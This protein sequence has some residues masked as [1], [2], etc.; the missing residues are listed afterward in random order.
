MRCVNMKWIRQVLWKIQSGHVCPTRW[1]PVYPL[2]T[3]LSEGYNIKAQMDITSHPIDEVVMT[4]PCL[5]SMLVSVFSV[6]KRRP[7]GTAN[8]HH[9]H[10][11]QSRLCLREYL[12]RSCHFWCVP[13]WTSSPQT[14]VQYVPWNMAH[15][16]FLYFGTGQFD[17]HPSGLLHWHCGNHMVAP[18]PVK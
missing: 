8:P 1:N 7:S 14:H 2:S 9:K 11:Q 18:V 10:P 6:R 13:T 12:T 17:P 5:I 4:Y 3:S 16:I 15:C